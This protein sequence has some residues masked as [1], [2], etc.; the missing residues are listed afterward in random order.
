MR[1]EALVRRGNETFRLL[2][3][4]ST[5]IPIGEVRR[6]ENDTAEPL[7]LIEVQSGAC[8]GED[9]IVRLE[10]NYGRQGQS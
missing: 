6:L 7:Y 2:A 3:N 5:Y 10:D 9:D 4:Q 1:G 8:L